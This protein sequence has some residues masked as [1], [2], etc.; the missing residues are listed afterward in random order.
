MNFFLKLQ[1]HYYEDG[2]V[3][4]VSHKEVEDSI[5]VTVSTNI[6]LCVSTM[7]AVVVWLWQLCV[8]TKDVSLFFWQNEI[9]TAKEFVDII[10]N[11]E[12][13]YQVS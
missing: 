11:A 13:D 6:S 9:Q 10:E 3:Q 5:P 2:N 1:V 4:L 7:C 8:K 12:N